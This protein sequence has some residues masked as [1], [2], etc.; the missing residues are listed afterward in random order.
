MLPR[1]WPLP[2]PTAC[3]VFPSSWSPIHSPDTS[4]SLISSSNPP[5]QMFCTFKLPPFPKVQF[6]SCF[7]SPSTHPFLVSS[8]PRLSCLLHPYPIS[9]HQSQLTHFMHFQHVLPS[10]ILTLDILHIHSRSVNPAGC[11]SSWV[12]APMK[13]TAQRGWG[14]RGLGSGGV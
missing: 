10:P 6:R 9:T 5:L 4:I 3:C 13:S 2:F 8:Y 11:L 12:P 14:H 7:M 1:W